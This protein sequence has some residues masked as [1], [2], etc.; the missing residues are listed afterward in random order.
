MGVMCEWAW[1]VICVGTWRVR[2]GRR[3]EARGDREED[4]RG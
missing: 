4:R 2:M 1:S 3:E